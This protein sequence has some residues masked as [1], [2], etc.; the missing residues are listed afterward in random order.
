MIQFRSTAQSSN[1]LFELLIAIRVNRQ[2]Y[3]IARYFRP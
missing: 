2:R 1:M 3:G